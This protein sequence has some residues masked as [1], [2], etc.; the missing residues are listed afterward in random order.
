MFTRRLLHLRK[1]ALNLHDRLKFTHEVKAN[2][3][4][5]YITIKEHKVEMFGDLESSEVMY[6]DTSD[7]AAGA[8]LGHSW[9]T[10]VF[11]V[12]NM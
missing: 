7:L 4:W 11:N 12:L 8:I 6:T 2:F 1:K 10:T 3:I 5:S 9:T